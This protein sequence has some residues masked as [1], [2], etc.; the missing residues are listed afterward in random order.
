MNL[1]KLTDFD[2]CRLKWFGFLVKFNRFHGLNSYW[3]LLDITL[4]YE[5]IRWFRLWSQGVKHVWD[6]YIISKFVYLYREG[7]SWK[8]ISK[9]RSGK[10]RV[11]LESK[12]SWDTIPSS[13]LEFYW[14]NKNF[15]LQYCDWISVF[16]LWNVAKYAYLLWL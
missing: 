7:T 5:V 11:F 8:C 15:D 13:L 14:N 1:K 4:N 10:S 6:E 2:I 12:W 3:I 9:R 16:V